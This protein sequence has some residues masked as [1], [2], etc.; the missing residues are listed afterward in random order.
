VH[1]RYPLFSWG[2]L[3]SFLQASPVFIDLSRRAAQWFR[4]LP[5]AGKAGFLANLIILHNGPAFRLLGRVLPVATTPTGRICQT[6]PNDVSDVEADDV[7][8]LTRKSLSH[9]PH[10]CPNT[11]AP[12]LVLDRRHRRRPEQSMSS[13]EI[14]WEAA[15]RRQSSWL[16]NL[17]RAA[18]ALEEWLLGC[19][20]AVASWPSWRT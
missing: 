6:E 5:C 20:V 13:R 7:S 11:S 17:S 9:F 16:R 8:S 18:G 14:V 1:R 15:R 10:L 2:R 3:K 19:L 4:F 12:F